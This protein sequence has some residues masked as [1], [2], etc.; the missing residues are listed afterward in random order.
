M[1]IF[2][3]QCG[4][5][6]FFENVQCVTCG[7]D[8]GWCES[9]REIAS[10]A[11]L[12]NGLFTCDLCGCSA[13][14]CRNYEV[15]QV[16][17]RFLTAATEGIEPSLCSACDLTATIPD[18]SVEGNRDRW[19]RLEQAK[20]RLLYQLDNLNLP[21]RSAQLPLS[22]DF[23]GNVLPAEGVWRKGELAEHVYTGH[24]DGKITI[25][26]QEADDIEREK[27]R[28]DMNEPHR[29]LI[30]HFR[31]EIGHYYWQ[32]LVQSKEDEAASVV[33]FGDHNNPD[34]ATALAQYY[35]QGPRPDWNF[36]YISAYASAHPWED[37]AE[38]FG[39]YLDVRSVLHTAE[40][41][42]VPLPKVDVDK[43][44]EGYVVAYQNLGI[45]VNELN[46]CLGIFDLVPEV[47]VPPVV[48]KLSFIHDLLTTAAKAQSR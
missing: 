11:P 38:T 5:R 2:T 27:L 46:R 45:M 20:R 3:C 44:I 12:E 17:N 33:L 24:S 39:L 9:C 37:F 26:I 48:E 22:F 36:S 25:N 7:R 14:K 47:I 28:V 43:G 35:G 29:T 19:R 8:V 15:E 34:Y 10:F 32:L 4:N 13:R 40:H 42:R 1:K 6:L 30:G 31:H 41:L 16:C 21:Y 23:K 18:L